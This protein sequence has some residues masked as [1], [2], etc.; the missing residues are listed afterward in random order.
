MSDT[1]IRETH[2]QRRAR[3]KTDSRPANR[4]FVFNVVDM[5]MKGTVDLLQKKMS[6]LQARIDTIEAGRA[7][8]LADCYRGP[9]NSGV[10][11]PRGTLVTDRGS[12]WLCIHDTAARPGETGDWRLIVKAGRDAR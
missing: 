8:T 9:W 11:Y 10:A 4:A 1:Q 2:A 12:C 5:T 6:A 3:Y 7:K